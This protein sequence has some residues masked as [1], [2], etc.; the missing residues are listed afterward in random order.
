MPA[1][2]DY[3]SVAAGEWRLVVLPRSWNI[4]LQRK[5]LGIIERQPSARHPQ[6]IFLSAVDGDSGSGLYLKVFHGG[7]G[8]A[9]CKD[10]VRKSKA[11]RA[12]RQ[13]MALN[14]AGFEAPLAIAAGEQRR[15]GLLRRAFILT[16]KVDAEGLQAVL[17]D[18]LVS[19]GDKRRLAAKRSG[20][21][22]LAGLIRQF[23]REGFVHG[24]MV[25]SNILVARADGDPPVFYLMDNDRTRRYPRWVPQSLWRRNLIQL[26][27]MPLPGITLQD[28]MRFLHAYLGVD[29]LSRSDRRLA[30]WLERKTRRR[31]SE[32]DGADTSVNFR[33]LMRWPPEHEGDGAEKV[34]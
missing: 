10:A 2:S 1:A 34:G 8:G 7:G 23:H 21:R 5:V 33:R 25:A 14:A 16:R 19:P 27:R 32:C 30:W 26:N 28:R 20:L 15:F 18:F 22:R 6:T 29:R 24:D 3:Q 9:V 11:F 12:W 13:G 17:R 4:E 31:R